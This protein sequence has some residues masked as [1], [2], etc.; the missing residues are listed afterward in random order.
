[1][2]GGMKQTH[3]HKQL[4]LII[5]VVV[6]IDEIC[7]AKDYKLVRRQASLNLGLEARLQ[8]HSSQVHWRS[9]ARCEWVARG[10]TRTQFYPREYGLK[11]QTAKRTQAQR[12][13]PTSEN[14][15]VRQI[16]RFFFFFKSCEIARE[17]KQEKKVLYTCKL[18][19]FLAKK[20]KEFR[21]QISIFIVR[22]SSL[23]FKRTFFLLFSC[24]GARSEAWSI[25]Q[26]IEYLL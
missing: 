1:M 11:T 20:K 25:Y 23:T 15:Q 4:I 3:T 22:T 6:R 7:G 12:V 2:A 19:R 17:P 10:A 21:D 14:K 9:A 8:C 13:V 24:M 26:E 16:F 18:D 5:V